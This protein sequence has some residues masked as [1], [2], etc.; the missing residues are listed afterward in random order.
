MQGV[1]CRALSLGFKLHMFSPDLLLRLRFRVDGYHKASAVLR[2]FEVAPNS[3]LPSPTTSIRQHPYK[4]TL[5]GYLSYKKPPPS[6]TLQS[7]HAWGP[8][9]VLRGWAVSYGR[10]TPALRNPGPCKNSLAVR[11]AFLLPLYYPQA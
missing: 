8:T 7:D 10:G 4:Q 5:Q 6:R 9:G 2:P 3:H 11:G 1:G